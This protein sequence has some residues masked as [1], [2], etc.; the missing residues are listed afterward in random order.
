MASSRR[1]L[2]GFCCALLTCLPQIALASP[3]AAERET[4]R[5]LM[6]EGDRFVAEGDL[7]AALARYQSAHAIM[8]V[9]TTGLS[10]ARVQA[11]LGML[12]E[13]RSTAMEVI[14]LP[15]SKSEPQVFA[16]ARRSAGTLATDL[17]PRVPSIKAVV[18]PPDVVFTLN[19]D[20]VALPPEARLVA[21]RTNP[22][23]HTLRIDAAGYASQTRRVTLTE[24]QAESVQIDLQPT[25][26]EAAP[27]PPAAVARAAAP[28]RVAP[29][30][31]PVDPAAPGR[32]RGIVGLSVG[33]ALLIAGT[34]TG[35][36]SLV[37]TSH[38]KDTCP[39]G[40][41]NTSQRDALSTANTLANV[42]NVCVPLGI[43]GIAYGFYELLTLPHGPSAAARS[44]GVDVA[45]T[46]SGAVVRGSL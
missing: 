31:E 34:V 16:D 1:L 8:H 4:A 43:L 36:M 18:T 12:V 22:G 23:P 38:E 26:A 5:S 9:P 29:A 44:G 19:V 13:A 40:H 21:F 30:A 46:G 35:V 33:G 3:S 11:Q 15:A 27:P 25:A 41:C 10:L 2:L 6:D 7:Q 39:D 24:G 37:K 17:E 28:I 20:G 14:N 42:A 32:T 45:F